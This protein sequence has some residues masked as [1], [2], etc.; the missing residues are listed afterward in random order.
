MI[1]LA[2]RKEVRPGERLETNEAVQLAGPIFSTVHVILKHA[3]A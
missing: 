2:N 3:G 1:I